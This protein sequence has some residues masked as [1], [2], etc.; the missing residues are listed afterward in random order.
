[1]IWASNWPH[2]SAPKDAVPDDAKLWT[3][4]IRPHFLETGTEKPGPTAWA[5][6]AAWAYTVSRAVDYLSGE[7]DID[8]KRLAVIAVGP[9]DTD[10]KPLPLPKKK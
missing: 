9:I 8:P 4:G 7:K 3:Q 10:G 2:P 1:M 6:I 5:T